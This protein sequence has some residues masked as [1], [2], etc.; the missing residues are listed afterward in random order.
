MKRM[1]SLATRAFVFSFVPVLVVLAL[2]FVA[3][4]TAIDRH[5]RAG[6]RES[7]EKSHALLQNAHR[8]S[9]LQIARFA[10]GMADSAGLKSTIQLAHEY[11]ANPEHAAEARR[12]I[13]AQLIPIHNLVGYDLLAVTDWKGQT[14]GAME[15]HAGV[16][17]TP[18]ELPAFTDPPS[19]MEFRAASTTLPPSQLPSTAASRSARCNSAGSSTSGA[20]RPAATP[21]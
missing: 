21:P 9:T 11:S 1:N 19:L 4:S 5:I 14:L 6:L 3:L 13:E 7:I 16:A 20:T 8:E 2:S 18:G 10:A 17:Q 15:F 12:T